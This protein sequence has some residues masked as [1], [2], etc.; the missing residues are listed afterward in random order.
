MCGIACIVNLDKI[1]R[2]NIHLSMKHRGPDSEGSYIDNNISIFPE[3]IGNLFNLYHCDLTNNELIA[4]PETICN[5]YENLTVFNVGLNYI[6]PPYPSCLDINVLGNQD[7]SSC[8]ED[9]TL[10]DLN[11]DETINILDVVILVE[12]ILSPAAV[13]LDGADINDDGN[14]N[15]I[16]V[17]QLVNTILNNE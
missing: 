1:D 11:S 13:E 4:L 14:V 6:C 2:E 5:I 7:I 3:S 15:I 8:N 16:D 17:V 10:G 9:F 12:H